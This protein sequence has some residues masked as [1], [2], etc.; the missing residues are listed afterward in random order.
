MNFIF[1]L[2]FSFLFALTLNLCAG[3]L[4]RHDGNASNNRGIGG[5]RFVIK[6]KL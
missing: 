3:N 1:K 2:L 5:S 4:E 6:K